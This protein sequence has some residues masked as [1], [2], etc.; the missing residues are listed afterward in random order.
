MQ[1]RVGEGYEGREKTVTVISD[2]KDRDDGRCDT[3][4]DYDE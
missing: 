2:A 1:G 4:E 3:D